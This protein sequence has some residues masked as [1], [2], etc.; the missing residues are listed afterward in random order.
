[1]ISVDTNVIVRFLTKDDPAQFQN[2][3]KLFQEQDIFICNTVVL[4]SEWV[5][6]FA[7]QFTSDRI[8]EA[9]RQL[10]GLPN[11]YL[12]NANAIA[13]AIEWYES[14]LDFA[15]AFHLVQSQHCAEFYTFDRK[16]L[17]KAKGLS[18]CELKQP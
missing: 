13:T 11:V 5:L 16:L 8:S 12:S 14:G 10:F 4:E 7:Y 9:F 17:R 6:R 2:S 18:R 15:D 3:F 1:M